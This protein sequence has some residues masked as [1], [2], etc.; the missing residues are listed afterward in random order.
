MKGLTIVFLL[1]LVLMTACTDNRRERVPPVDFSNLEPLLNQAGDTVYVINF[2]ATWCKPCIEELPSFEKVYDEYNGR[3]FRMILVSL[4]FPTKYEE[5]LL[6]FIKERGLK[7]EVIHL[8]EVN[9]NDWI[10]RV[11]PS[12]SGA[13]PA[14]LVYKGDDRD[15]YERKLNYEELKQIVESKLN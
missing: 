3:N 4:D 1:A 13:I 14:T 12:W 8:T 11:D 2:W 5:N 10:D 7:P 6:P 15:F 9:A